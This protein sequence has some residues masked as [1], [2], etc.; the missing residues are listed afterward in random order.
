MTQP[1]WMTFSLHLISFCKK[2]QCAGPFSRVYRRERCLIWSTFIFTWAQSEQ[3]CDET[4]DMCVTGTQ[5]L[6]LLALALN[7]NSYKYLKTVKWEKVGAQDQSRNSLLPALCGQCVFMGVHSIFSSIIDAMSVFEY[8]S[9]TQV[10]DCLL[11]KIRLRATCL[12]QGVAEA[13]RAKKKKETFGENLRA[14]FSQSAFKIQKKKK[15]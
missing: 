13:L 14:C 7:V 6:T 3:E 2:R 4:H 10:N 15:M 5:L 12:S 9:L 1:F 11:V 8:V